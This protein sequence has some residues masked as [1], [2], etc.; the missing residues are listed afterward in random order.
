MGVVALIA[1][2]LSL[3]MAWRTF[4]ESSPAREGSLPTKPITGQWRVKADTPIMAPPPG[5]PADFMIAK[6]VRSFDATNASAAG[7]TVSLTLANG[8]TQEAKVMNAQPGHLQLGVTLPNG[9]PT[10]LT[11]A[12]MGDGGP[13][14]VTDGISTVIFEPNSP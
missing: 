7:G 4:H 6:D 8:S 5:A 9:K 11:I 13:V 3:V 14:M 1:I 10:Q 2:I 12:Q